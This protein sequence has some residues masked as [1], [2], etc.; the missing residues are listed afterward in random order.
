MLFY[1]FNNIIMKNKYLFLLI[2]ALIFSATNVSADDSSI[3]TTN[4]VRIMTGSWML[5]EPRLESRTE[6]KA[7]REELKQEVKTKKEEI[8][9]NREDY[10]KEVWEL[11]EIFSEITDEQ[12][13]ELKNLREEHRDNVKEIQEKLKNKELTLEE[14]EQLRT[15]LDNEVSSYAESIKEIAWDNSEVES[16]VN[17]RLELRDKNKS[18][19]E[20]IKNSREEF[21][22]ERNELVL[23]FKE[24]YYWKVAQVIPKL[25]DNNLEK[26]S[27]K[28]DTLITKTEANAKLSKENKDKMVA[29][30]ISL[31]EILDEELETRDILDEDLEIELEVEL[32]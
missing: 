20:D 5:K 27:V 14:R 15:E 4:K 2:A 3:S 19:R 28:I 25:A 31:K 9:N 1:I 21:R 17:S 7:K 30:L 26:L 16:Y 29:Q 13:E 24:A 18:I 10:K 23:E 6:I 8:K 11:K 32:D 22:G 12:K